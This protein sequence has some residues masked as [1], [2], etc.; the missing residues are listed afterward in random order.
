MCEFS[1]KLIAWLDR[2]LSV[3]ETAEVE[4]HLEGC[5]ECRSGVEA[6]KRVSGEFDAYCDATMASNARREA[7]RWA[8]V[9]IA[10]GAVAALVALFLAMPRARVQA[11]VSHSSQVSI[12][13]S[14]A[15]AAAAAVPAAIRPTMRRVHR[16]LAAAS[17]SIRNQDSPPPQ[18][19]NS[20]FLPDEPM[21]QIAIPADEMFPPGAVPEGIHFVAD[22]TIA[23]D[24]SAER[25]SL[26]PRL[27]S[28][29]R[30]TTQP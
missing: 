7:P 19:Q 15:V 26:R 18:N 9:A 27:A 4:R 5:S 6:Y 28:Y 14:P 1:G 24:G 17:V 29:E 13:A 12:A 8:P 10:A 21:I 2:E 11:P 22:L 16:R 20:N 30:R 3:G 23:A 25:L